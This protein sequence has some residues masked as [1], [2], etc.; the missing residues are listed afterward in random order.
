M[1]AGNWAFVTAAYAVTWVVLLG[2]LAH[3]HRAVRRARD[4]LAQMTGRRPGE[5]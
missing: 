1:L 2:Y 4:D 3:V 5:A